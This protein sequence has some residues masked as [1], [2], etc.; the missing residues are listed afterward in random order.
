MSAVV[1]EEDEEEEEERIRR[2]SES[3]SATKARTS[4]ERE[5]GVDRAWS[6]L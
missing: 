3:P 5:V 6:C 2:S 4:L 1:E